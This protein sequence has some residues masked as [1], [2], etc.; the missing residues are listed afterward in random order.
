M[1]RCWRSVVR[2]NNGHLLFIQ[3]SHSFIHPFMYLLLHSRIVVFPGN[4]RRLV[5]GACGCA[6]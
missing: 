3:S 2:R 5:A 4:I 1:R 6:A